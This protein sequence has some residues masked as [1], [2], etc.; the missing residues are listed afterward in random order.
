MR[1][2]TQ[3]VVWVFLGLTLLAGCKK[4]ETTTAGSASA[5]TSGET[6]KIAVIPKGTTHAY[7]KSVEAGARA[8]AKE[9]GVEVV[10][11]GPVQE[12]DRSSQIQIVEQFASEPGISGLVLAPLDDEALVD[13]VKTVTDKGIPVVIID[14]GLRGKP[15]TDFASFFATNNHAAGELGGENLA[16]LL[17][18]KGNVVLLK[19]NP[20]SASTQEREDGFLE[21]MAKYPLI[22]IISKDQYAGATQD[23]AKTKAMSMNDKLTAAQGIFCPNESST[24]GMLGAL[25]DLGLVG[26]VKFVG[27][28]ASP[29]LVDA[30]RSKQIDVL[31]SQDPFKMG[32]EAV[33]TCVAAIRKQKV[34]PI[35]DT[36]TAVVTLDN[37]DTPAIAK[38]LGK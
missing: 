38:V 7:W 13:P 18:G 31:I 28:D 16:R 21:A 12:N 2:I 19:Y 1:R 33:K 29:A 36:G 11:K 25:E 4:S 8:A 9:L 26:K 32:Y 34:E 17:N 37:V 24:L 35:I 10:Y 20:G 23:S 5:N 15:G 22:T 30:L 14:S 3:A 6:L 27:F